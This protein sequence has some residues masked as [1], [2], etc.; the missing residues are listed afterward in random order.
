MKSSFTSEYWAPRLLSV[1]RM[2]CGYIVLFNGWE[3]IRENPPVVFTGATDSIEAILFWV[4]L[5]CGAL[6]L[7]GLFTRLVATFL[8]LVTALK[9][10]LFTVVYGHYPPLIF[11]DRLL[12]FC[13]V[14][15]FVSAAGPGQW[16]LD[17]LRGR[18]G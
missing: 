10:A 3:R 1:L 6:L 17:A 11:D 16:G 15:L 7:V 13:F 12:L 5:A 18:Q 2:V 14:F 9:Y 4:G 8:F